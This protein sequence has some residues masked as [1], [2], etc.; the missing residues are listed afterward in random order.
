MRL[1]FSF[2]FV[3]VNQQSDGSGAW[4]LGGAH[5]EGAQSEL[6]LAVI[7]DYDCGCLPHAVMHL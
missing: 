7:T 2:N 5:G 6:H 1:P 3:N 4:E